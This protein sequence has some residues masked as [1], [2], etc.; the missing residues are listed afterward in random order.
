MGTLKC[1]GRH[2]WTAWT[3]SSKELRLPGTNTVRPGGLD[4]AQIFCFVRT[5][6]LCGTS[7]EQ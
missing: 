1:H 2:V 3:S 5:C 7:E 6:T 4:V